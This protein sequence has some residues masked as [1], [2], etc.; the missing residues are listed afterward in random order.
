MNQHIQSLSDTDAVAPLAASIEASMCTHSSY[1]VALAG[2]PASGKSTIASHLVRHLNR[3][4]ASTNTATLIPMDGFHLDNRILSLRNQLHRKGTPE[5]FDAAGFRRALQQLLEAG[6][7]T[8]FPAFDRSL[9][10]SIAGAIEVTPNTPVVVIEGNYLLLKRKPW[11]DI[12]ALFD[13]TVFIEVD[14]PVIEQ[15]LIRR[16]LEHDLA[17]EDAT[18]RTRL[19]DLPNAEMVRNESIDADVVIRQS[20]SVLS[21]P[22]T[23]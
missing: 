11:S 17:F 2:P 13:L 22:A 3:N 12:H 23:E 4:N 20:E 7:T 14:T 19:N 6:E 9:D 21:D 10:L 15:R 8:F 1:V 5:T 18:Q 16:W